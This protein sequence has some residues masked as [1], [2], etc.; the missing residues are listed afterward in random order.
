M[1]LPPTEAAEVY[2]LGVLLVEVMLP[3]LDSRQVAAVTAAVGRGEAALLA[4]RC[5]PEVASLASWLL[6]EEWKRP[7]VKM[8]LAHAALMEH[9]QELQK[10]S[11]VARLEVSAPHA[12][13]RLPASASE[14]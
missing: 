4:E 10:W 6:S 1:R 3:G 8:A 13:R 9:T 11:V 2:A 5:G 12:S 7:T 14:D